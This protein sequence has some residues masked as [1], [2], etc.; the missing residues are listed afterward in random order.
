MGRVIFW[1]FLLVLASG[2]LGATVF[3]DQI[4]SATSRAKPVTPVLEQNVDANGYI[5]THE[6]GTANVALSSADA[7]RL[8]AAN[9]KLD[10]A[11]GHL[12][13]IESQAA[14]LNFDGSGNLKTAPQGTQ[15]VHIDNSSITTTPNRPDNFA[16]SRRVDISAGSTQVYA[17]NG[18][19]LVSLVAVGGADDSVTINFRRPD[20]FS[21]LFLYGGGSDGIDSYQLP[22]TTPI[23]IN[24]VVIHCENFIQDCKL[25]F[26]AVGSAP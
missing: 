23:L 2:V 22:L 21:A 7:G 20:G 9:A 4:A 12:A 16:F 13:N 14:K 17:P 15:T 8:D 5:R 6:Q 11:N 19:L 10:T 26:T 18:N 1:A 25:T 3:S 24:A